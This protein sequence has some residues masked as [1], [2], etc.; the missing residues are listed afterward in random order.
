MVAKNEDLADRARKIAGWIRRFQ[1][2]LHERQIT[3]PR[4]VIRRLDYFAEEI[5]MMA[6]YL[7]TARNFQNMRDHMRSK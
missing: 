4:H 6:L 5:N 2:D 1:M 3:E 7:E